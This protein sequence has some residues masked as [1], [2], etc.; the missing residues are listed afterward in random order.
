MNDYYKNKLL[1][2]KRKLQNV[3]SE[4][5]RNDNYNR[6]LNPNFLNFEKIEINNKEPSRNTKL[7]KIISI[8][9]DFELKKEEKEENNPFLFVFNKIIQYK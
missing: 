7:T 3:L 5:E 1:L 6:F 8:E 2:K 9:N 4:E